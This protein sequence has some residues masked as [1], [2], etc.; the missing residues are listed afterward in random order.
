MVVNIGPIMTESAVKGVRITADEVR[1]IAKLARLR[2]DEDEVRRMVDEI[3]AILGYI[4]TVKNLDVGAAEPM[5][6]AVAFDCPLRED[7]PA[8]ALPI[9]EVLANAP[10]REGSFFQVPRIIAGPGSEEG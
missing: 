4:D 7:E 3:G 1:E 9:D 2:L 10:R 6:H 8:P 5:S